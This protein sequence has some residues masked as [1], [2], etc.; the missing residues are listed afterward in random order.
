MITD[1]S[2]AVVGTQD[3]LPFGEDGGV[4]GENEKHRFTNYERD[5][6]SG[7]YY[8][9]NRQYSTNTGR[10]MRPDP[11]AG[12]IADP[13]S[14]NRYSYVV[15]DPINLFDPLGLD[16]C[17]KKDKDGKIIVYPCP[18]DN[19][20]PDPTEPIKLQAFA[21]Y[22]L[23]VGGAIGIATWSSARNSIQKDCSISYS[24]C[25]EKCFNAYRLDNTVRGL[26]Q[27]SGYPGIGEFL[28]DV[29]TTATIAS[30]VNQG[31]NALF[32]GKRFVTEGAR[33]QT[34]WSH[35][36]LG[37]PGLGNYVLKPLGLARYIPTLSK[38]GQKLGVVLTRASVGVLGFEAGHALGTAGYCSAVCKDCNNRR[39][40]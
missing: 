32:G 7:T 40:P 23:D 24:E 30:L 20:W 18:P 27:L 19:P 2:G 26:G 1:G 6:E 21:G 29:T 28:A 37:R 12:S 35:K 36:A 17:T 31:L 34:S 11:V 10:F 25:M 14:L 4:T 15:N 33:K 22:L 16:I 3:H 9:V 39:N 5:S 8:A 38:V 13:Q